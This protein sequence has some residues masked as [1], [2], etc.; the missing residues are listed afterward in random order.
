ML[1]KPTVAAR[2]AIDN[3]FVFSETSE[4]N[5]LLQHHFVYSF[6]CEGKELCGVKAFVTPALALSGVESSPPDRSVPAPIAP[7]DGSGLRAGSRFSALIRL[8][9]RLAQPPVNSGLIHG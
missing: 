3:T 1:Q 9:R 5:P 2:Q 7:S 6:I 4:F 8:V